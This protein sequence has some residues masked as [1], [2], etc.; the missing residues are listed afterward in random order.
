MAARKPKKPTLTAA[1][2]AERDA[3]AQHWMNQRKIERVAEGAARHGWFSISA[4]N[5]RKAHEEGNL[6][7]D[8]EDGYSYLSI[9]DG[10]SYRIESY[11][12][13]H[14]GKEFSIRRVR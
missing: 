6:A 1:E 10:P 9:A 14:E 2:K 3:R 5:L 4:E 12:P 7:D 13:D 11:D 8:P